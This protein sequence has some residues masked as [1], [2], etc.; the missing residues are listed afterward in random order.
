MQYVWPVLGVVVTFAIAVLLHEFGH[1]I[2]ARLSG[3][4]VDVF[5]VGFGKRLWGIRRGITDYQLSALPLGG[6]VKL[7]GVF[8]KETERYLHGDETETGDKPGDLPACTA[9]AEAKPPKSAPP[10]TTGLAFARDMIEDAAALRN[11]P[12]LIRVFVFSAGCG[13]NY[14]V[15]AAVLA[16]MAIRGFHI[17]LPYQSFVGPVKEGSPLYEAGL[18]RGDRII[19]FDGLPVSRWEQAREEQ[20]QGILDVLAGLVEDRDTSRP[21]P[22]VVARTEAGKPTT[23]SLTL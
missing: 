10:T 9:P 3:V 2:A 4:G 6:Y 20:S 18:R 17:D 1:F 12:W 11:K 21:I 13:F 5:S 19:R 23:F 15:A 14:L 7:R 16:I 22:C 8:P